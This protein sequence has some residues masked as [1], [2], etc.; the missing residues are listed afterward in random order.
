M[1]RPAGPRFEIYLGQLSARAFSAARTRNAERFL[2]R[3][4]MRRSNPTFTARGIE[5]NMAAAASDLVP[6]FGTEL[7]RM[8]VLIICVY[9]HTIRSG[10]KRT[11]V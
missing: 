2:A 8:A 5:L 3:S 1:A 4:S 6:A 9:I 11:G 7:R 10:A